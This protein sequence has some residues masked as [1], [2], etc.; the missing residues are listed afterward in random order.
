MTNKEI[1]RFIRKY[2]GKDIDFYIDNDKTKKIPAVTYCFGKDKSTNK[3]IYVI[4]LKGKIFHDKKLP[5]EYLHAMI[6]HEIGHIKKNHFYRKMSKAKAEFEAQIWAITKSI[7]YKLKLVKCYLIEIFLS[8]QTLSKHKNKY[9][10]YVAFKKFS[11]VV[12]KESIDQWNNVV[13]NLAK[14]KI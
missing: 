11:K 12:G 13:K 7:K 4:V 6:L 3:N 10:Y 5:K 9:Y 14:N 2:G 8:W 1:D